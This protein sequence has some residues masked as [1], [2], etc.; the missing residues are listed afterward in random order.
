MLA[1][2]PAGR[3][4]TCRVCC[5]Q[6]VNLLLPIQRSGAS[7]RGG[8]DWGGC[9]H[10]TFA[11]DRFWD[12]CKSDEFLLGRQCSRI[13]ILRFFQISKKRLF[14]FFLKY[15][16]V[17]KVISKSLVLNPS[18]WVHRPIL[19]SVITVIQFPATGVWSI[20]SHCWTFPN[21]MGTY[22]RLSHTVLSC[23]VSCVCISQQDVWYWWLTGTDF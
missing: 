9:V 7:P 10:P 3:A 12:W 15:Q 19:R 16:K 6:A 14:T 21:V 17:V 1:S 23:I 22:R 4:D 5:L 13:H 11:R 18:K 20:L 2:K 8:L